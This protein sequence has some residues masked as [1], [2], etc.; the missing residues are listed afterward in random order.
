MVIV[1]MRVGTETFYACERHY[2]AMKK[3]LEANYYVLETQVVENKQCDRCNKK[4]PIPKTAKVV[5]YC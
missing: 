4:W 3:E 1:E 2:K 5:S